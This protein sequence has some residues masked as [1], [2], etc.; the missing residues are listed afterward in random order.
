MAADCLQGDPILARQQHD[1]Y[2]V[3]EMS[4]RR[5]GLRARRPPS[6]HNALRMAARCRRM[7]GVNGRGRRRLETDRAQ[8]V[9]P[10]LQPVV[11]GIGFACEWAEAHGSTPNRQIE[12]TSVPKT[13][14]PSPRRPPDTTPG[15]SLE[16][17]NPRIRAAVNGFHCSQ[18][19]SHLNTFFRIVPWTPQLASTTWVT[20][21]S[22]PT[23]I[24]EIASSSLIRC[25]VIRNRRSL[26]NASR[27]AR[28]RL[29]W[30]AISVC[31]SGPSSAR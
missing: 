23:D 11:F 30:L 4:Q 6:Q 5:Y 27:I 3:G 9:P 18:R 16:V 12:A 15:Y 10:R 21:K 22:A 17:C 14:H 8:D 19:Q 1:R 7:P 28:S 29:E 31:A 24:S 13:G 20:P 2:V 25:T 26:R